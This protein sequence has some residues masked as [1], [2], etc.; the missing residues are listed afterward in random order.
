MASIF[1]QSYTVKDKSGKRI[2]KKSK[3]WYI[4][5]KAADGIRKRIKGFKDKQATTQLAAELER[6][7]ELAQAGIIDRYAEHRKKPLMEH[8]EDFY[9]ALLA[10]GRTTKHAQQTRYRL[11]QILHGCKFTVW[12]DIVASRVQQ[13]L[14]NLRSG[15]DGISI[16]TSNY[17]LQA[18]KQFC[19]WMVQ[20]GRAPESPVAHLAKLNA[21][22]DRRHERRSLE[23]EEIRLLLATTAAGPKRFGM[24][25]CERALLYR[26]AAESGLR[27]NELR[28]LKV[29]SFDFK[30]FTLTVRVGDTKNRKLAVLPLKRE[31]AAE[32]RE[33]F[34]GKMPTTKAFGGTYKR[35]TLKTADML[36]ADLADAG[37]P[38]VDNGGRY[39]DFH[40]LR[41]TTGSLLAA[42]GVHPK[43]AQSI[44]RHCDIN[45]T[46][47]RYTHTLRGQESR[48]IEGLPDLRSPSEG[49]QKLMGT[50]NTPAGAYKPAY[51]KL[52]KNAYSDSNQISSDGIANGVEVEDL[53]E[54]SDVGNSLSLT[55][56]DNEKESLAATVTT[57]DSNAPG[58]TRTCNPR[59]RSPRLYPIE[60]RAQKFA[61]ACKITSLH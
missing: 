17:Y 35:L 24:T 11:E 15:G 5:F 51:K 44:M 28:S 8:M 49:E 47:L 45:L 27:A 29:S 37:I 43:V 34:Q 50:D 52:A 32:L 6:K 53:S 41:H 20:D 7:A 48:A 54:T 31:T 9:Q 10:K 36:K 33:F 13:V 21:S 61:T 23:L 19:R 2:R 56:L 58:R 14:A 16:Q 25:G 4:D 38:Y 22:K 39:A 40:S 60:L 55:E 26:L 12:G 42:T 30:N 1:R 3:F 57:K 59:I 46:M 18:I